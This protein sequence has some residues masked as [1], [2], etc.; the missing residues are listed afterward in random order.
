MMAIPSRQLKQSKV[1]V[2]QLGYEVLLFGDE[3]VILE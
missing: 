1:A 3:V 2:V